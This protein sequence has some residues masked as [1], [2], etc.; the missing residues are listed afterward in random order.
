MTSI[1]YTL[2]QE[3]FLPNEERLLVTCHVGKLLK[4]KN[5]FL[6]IV[7]SISSPVTITIVQIKQT[8]KSFKRKRTWSLAELKLVDGRN[9]QSD[10]Q[11]FDLHLDKIYHWEALN[12][13]DR[14]V[15]IITLWKQCNRYIIKDK[16]TFKNVPK[17]WITDDA[18]T[19]EKYINS[20][21]LELEND[22]ESDD[23]QAITDKEQEDLTKCVLSIKFASYF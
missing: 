11:E 20:P 19:P 7:S 12:A 14:Q 15:F 4:K 17:A 22:A 23:F 5:T 9:E 8:D 3:V 10:F 2:Q 16:P 18:V 1:R 6:C 21:I 13:L